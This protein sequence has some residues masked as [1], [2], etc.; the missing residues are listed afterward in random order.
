MAASFAGW[1]IPTTD[2]L[3]L[4]RSAA[5][6]GVLIASGGVRNGIDVAKALTLGAELGRN[7]RAARSRRCGG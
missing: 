7:C 3:I 2:A 1:G 4:A 6:G 5:P